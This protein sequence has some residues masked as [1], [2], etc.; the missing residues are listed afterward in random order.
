MGAGTQMLGEP[1][2][3]STR[4]VSAG[5][6][7]TLLLLQLGH[8][9]AVVWWLVSGAGL[10]GCFFGGECQEGGLSGGR[11]VGL[12][13]S[14]SQGLTFPLCSAEVVAVPG[15]MFQADSVVVLKPS[16]WTW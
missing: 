10:S 5:G 4:S 11:S 7:F 16:V 2:G 9:C 14:T 12:F 8:G 3:G 15:P 13:S 6:G 1:G